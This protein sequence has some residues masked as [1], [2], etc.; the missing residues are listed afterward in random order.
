[1]GIVKK[2]KKIL[3]NKTV[4]RS[5]EIGKGSLSA[6]AAVNAAKKEMLAEVIKRDLPQ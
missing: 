6:L 3:A 1:M 5:L 4:K 2:A